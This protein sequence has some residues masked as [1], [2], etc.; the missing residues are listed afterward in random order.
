MTDNRTNWIRDLYSRFF[1]ITQ[2]ISVALGRYAAKTYQSAKISNL[3]SFFYAAQPFAIVF[4]A[5]ALVL[6]FSYQHE[7]RIARAWQQ[8]SSTQSGNTAIRESLEYLNRDDAWPFGKKRKS[9]DGIVIIPAYLTLKRQQEGKVALDVETCR[10]YVNLRRV[11]LPSAE[12]SDAKFICADLRNANLRKAI[13]YHSDLRNTRMWNADLRDA[14][15]QG[16]K[17]DRTD[18][19]NADLRNARLELIRSLPDDPEIT[20]PAVLWITEETERLIANWKVGDEWRSEPVFE[21]DPITTSLLRADLRNADLRGAHLDSANLTRSDLRNA[22]M[23]GARLSKAN[24]YK[25]DIRGVA[26]VTCDQL[27]SA[28]N[29]SLSYR[30]EEL[31]CGEGIPKIPGDP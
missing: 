25:A 29:W 23:D 16:A 8:L 18:L 17:L 14:R 9:L 13:L 28:E 12:L 21:S 30:N 15:L 2:R 6:E 31:A 11:N 5:I 20:L 27:K 4:A 19:W 22:R 10:Q 7:E 1:H 26:G 3:L 24:L